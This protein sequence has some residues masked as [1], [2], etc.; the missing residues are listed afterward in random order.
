MKCYLLYFS[1]RNCQYASALF[2]MKRSAKIF[3]TGM[4]REEEQTAPSGLEQPIFGVGVHGNSNGRLRPVP[5]DAKIVGKQA[6]ISA[7]RNSTRIE[8]VCFLGIRAGFRGAMFHLF[9]KS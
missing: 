5:R 2:S 8:V 4:W 9:S 1:E 3:L 7:R 6:A